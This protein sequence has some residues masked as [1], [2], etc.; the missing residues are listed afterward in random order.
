MK[1]IQILLCV[2]AAACFPPA[3]Q[4]DGA[5]VVSGQITD[6]NGAPVANAA[7]TLKDKKNKIE[8]ATRTDDFG[9]YVIRARAGEFKV[10]IRSPGF[11]ESAKQEVV[12][13]PGEHERVDVALDVGGVSEAITVSAPAETPTVRP[14]WNAWA[15]LASPTPSFQPVE[16]LETGDKSYS[17]VIDLAAFAYKNEPGVYSRGAG[18]GL[19]EWLLSTKLSEVN[20]KLL[21]IPDESYFE[22]LATGERVVTMRLNLKRL[23]EALKD[24]VRVRRA[25]LEELRANPD[26]DFKFGRAVVNLRT[27]AREGVGRVAFVLWAD[28]S[29]PLD[30]LTIPLCLAG[31]EQ[32][33][34]GCGDGA[35]LYD[36]LSGLD[37]IR[38]AAQSQ[39]RQTRPDSALHFI[40]LEGRHAIGIFRDNSWPADKFVQWNLTTNARGV[41]DYIEKTLIPNFD[42]AGDDA[43]LLQVGSEL[44]NL[45]FPLPSAREA[46]DA[47]NEF[48]RARLKNDNPAD[49]PSIF[50]RMLSDRY[51]APYLIP[52]GLMA[53]DVDG[54]KDF[55]GFHFRVQMPL[56]MQ[57]YRADNGCI[58]NWVVLAPPAN[59]AGT[60]PELIAA[61]AGFANWFTKWKFKEMDEVIPR[62][63]NWIGE[64]V[65]EREP[66][67][68]FILAHQDRDALYFESGQR[69]GAYGILR[70]FKTPSVAIVNACGTS[71]PGASE[72]I[73]R[74]NASGISGIIGTTGLVR[75]KLAGAFFAVLGETLAEERE[76]GRYPLGLAHFHTLRKL[77]LK[78]PDDISTHPAYGAKVLAYQLLGNSDLRICT[79]PAK[80]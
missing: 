71:G 38:A 7:V 60:P 69:V 70:R 75:P 73:G 20:L 24:S 6:P 22:P 77:R 18:E 36:S 32:A 51:E 23:R 41:L 64:Y 65:E 34:K 72:V 49:P 3:P 45:L 52:L 40:Q 9:K 10:A 42:R 78:H 21:V 33:A 68:L 44:H 67:A 63:G 37:P 80:N 31:D 35:G 76:G 5:A 13:A 47:F 8:W 55:L 59:K 74:L 11:K 30:E 58:S 26:A 19:R 14:T 79:P 39:E 54:H 4:V 1:L 17:L 29:L 48:L 15:E 57:D 12:L 53:Y 43:T 27:R 56:Q 62:F 16:F 25:P 66:V 61:R 28:G 46:R 2:L 50:V